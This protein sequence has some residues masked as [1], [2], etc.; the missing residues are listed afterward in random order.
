MEVIVKTPFLKGA[1]TVC[2]VSALLVGCSSAGGEGNGEGADGDS[3]LDQVTVQ[4]DYVPRGNH[5]MFYV[6]D[7]LGY[8]KD[9]GIAVDSITKGTGSPDALRIV[10]NGKADFGFGDLPSLVTARS[11]GVDVTTLAAVNQHSPLGM[12]SVADKHELKKADDLKGLKIGVHPAGST[13]IFWKALLQ[14]NGM[15]ASDVKE[16][17]VTPP[18]ES[19]L[20]TGK[21]DSIICYID[22]EVPELEAKAGGEGSLSILLGADAGY[23]VYGS[24]LFTSQKMIDDDLE[25]VQRFTNAYAK[26]FE[27]VDKHP[28]KAAKILAD[29]S[30]ELAGKEDIFEQQLQADIDHTF[31]S[32]ATQEHGL[33][34]MEKSEWED[35]VNILDEQGGLKKAP[36]VDELYD[37]TFIDKANK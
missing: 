20:L 19:Y 28:A 8:F 12:C 25:L 17:T 2:A 11:Q 6:A 23:D 7:K 10:G 1:L 21:V 32:E 5:A 37:S 30:K 3:S 13:Y 33:G 15:S 35:T 31:E 14:A 18:Y 34:A 22:A 24:G 16:L 4:L 9:E 36:A 27:Y 29:S 26:A